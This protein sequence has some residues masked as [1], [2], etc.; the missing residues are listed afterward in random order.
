MMHQANRRRALFLLL[1]AGTIPA[2]IF[3]KEGTRSTQQP[4]IP[5]AAQVN[6]NAGP[7]LDIAKIRPLGHWY[8]TEVPDTLDLADRAALA[9]N[10]L[11][12]EV[13]PKD[14]YGIYQSYKFNANP[15][16]IE[17]GSD[18]LYGVVL[19]P[20]SVRTLPMLR[21]MSGS[22]FGIETERDMM[23]ALLAQ[24]QRNGQ[25]VYPPDLDSPARSMSYPMRMAMMAFA[26]ETWYARDPN[27]QWL[28]WFDLLTNGLK[29]DAI[30]VG[31][32]AYYPVQTAI[33]PKGVWHDM[34]K[35]DSGPT[36][37]HS[38]EEAPQDQIGQEGTAKNDLT[39]QL[40]TMVFDYRL[41]GDKD[42]LQ[43][44]H[45]IKRELLRPAL[46]VNTNEQGYPGNEHAVWE[47]HFHANAHTLLGLLDLADVSHDQWLQEFVR[48]GYA[49]AIRN[50]LVRVGWFPA[51]IHPTKFGRPAWLA[52][53][54]EICGVGDM[55]LLGVRLSDDGI[56]DHWDDVDSIVRNQLTAQQVIDVDL[57]RRAAGVTTTAYDKDFERFR[58]GF[59]LGGITTIDENGQI[60]GCC[61][62]NGSAALYY[63]WEGV[64]R[65]HDKTATV[66][67]FL[68]RASPWMDI[69]S[70]LPYE[71]K[72]VLH[73]KLASTVMVRVPA[74][75]DKST[76][77]IDVN[78]KPVTVTPAGRYLMIGDLSPKDV[79]TLA[80][81]IKQVVE[82]DTIAGTTYTITF[83]G[84][85]IV[86]IQ[87]R[88]NG[89]HSYPLYLR[90]AFTAEKAPMR[91]KRR[92]VAD[93][94]IPLGV[95]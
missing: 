19:E 16:H 67:L 34:V 60:A 92:Y 46:W 9:I 39:R 54:D 48:E 80:F 77:S 84:S 50:G 81:P 64:T 88:A 12:G 93:R 90:S 55:V 10:A 95:Y 62:G 57:M 72:V 75:L 49:N 58:G 65:F 43:L 44:A 68:N 41:T 31:D 28:D 24:V 42:S 26:M 30:H 36:P 32:R 70:Y 29:K 38:P 18:A 69:D 37:Y 53:S 85:T 17:G 94:L 91:M 25:M 56:G 23:R 21:A 11:I 59:G 45:E 3:G 27:P 63:A 66:N 2:L 52:E 8:D 76:V 20:R 4:P 15:P 87:P 82:K 83:R 7:I 6:M 14:F 89:P 1:A 74:W 79:I 13:D 5:S 78:G 47:G 71:G 22:S 86:D 40:S 33:D 51:W 35:G 73:N 61:T